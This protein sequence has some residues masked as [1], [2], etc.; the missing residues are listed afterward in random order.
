VQL[1]VKQL[2]LDQPY[3]DLVIASDGTTNLA[4]VLT[5]SAAATSVPAVKPLARSVPKGRRE[6]RKPIAPAPVLPLQLTIDTVN[7]QGGSANFEDYSIKPNFVTGLQALAGTITGISSQPNSRA[8]LMLDGAVDKYAPAH[9]AGEVNLLA[10]EQYMDIKASFRNMELTSLSPYSGKFAG[11]V[12]ERG[13]L[14]MDVSYLIRNR[15]I[16]AQHKILLT[17]LQLGDKVDSPDAT[18]LPLRL[19]VAL[20]KDADGNID[21]DIPVTGDLDDPKFRVGPIIWKVFLNLCSKAVTAPFAL[22]GKLFGGDDDLQFV[23]FDAG[24]A[25]LDATMSERVAKLRKAMQGR[26][27]LAL[28]I[29]LGSNA[30]LD[31]AA[32][33]TAAWATRLDGFAPVATRADRAQYLKRLEKAYSEAYGQPLAALKSPAPPAPAGA[34]VSAEAVREARIAALEEGLKA[35]I[36]VGEPELEALGQARARAVQDALLGSGEIDPLRVF[37]VAP[38]G[39]AAS[40]GKV[41]V[42]LSIRS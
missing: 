14:S 40:A 30:E 26:P 35:Q 3:V 9:F 1:A 42:P 23:D 20:L 7:I 22:L 19:V 37:I 6:A 29:P 27:G 10:A 11:Y 13:K 5:A 12:I 39:A 31:G 33:R 17:Q 38:A 21:L 36:K 41:R 24:A 28:E 4:D 8:L 25:T 32:I 2:D 34:P 15:G 16:E 18:S